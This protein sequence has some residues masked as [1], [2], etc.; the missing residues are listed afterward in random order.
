[1]VTELNVT[2][3]SSSNSLPSIDKI[4]SNNDENF[5]TGNKVVFRKREK[6]ENDHGNIYMVI[7][8]CKVESKKKDMDLK[9]GSTIKVV[10]TEKRD[11]GLIEAEVN[12]KSVLIPEAYLVEAV[13]EKNIIPHDELEYNELTSRIGSGAYG[14]VYKAKYKNEFVAFKTSINKMS[15]PN[16]MPKELEEELSI[17]S[18]LKNRN[19][20]KLIGECRTMKHMGLVIEYCAGGTLSDLI[21]K[22]KINDELCYILYLKQISDGMSYLHNDSKCKDLLIGNE[23]YNVIHRDLKPQNILIKEA[24]CEHDGPS[25]FDGDIVKCKKC[26]NTYFGNVTLK[27]ADFGLSKLRSQL[28][29]NQEKHFSIQGTLPYTA[30]EVIRGICLRQ[31]D[32]YSFS[33]I[34]WE[35]VHKK[36]PGTGWNKDNIFYEIG[37]NE[38]HLEFE[39]DCR[40]LYKEIFYLCNDKDDPMHRPSFQ[41]ISESLIKYQDIVIKERKE[42]LKIPD[43]KEVNEST[44]QLNC[45]LEKLRQ[46]VKEEK[47]DLE[48][49]IKELRPSIERL[50]NTKPELRK[51]SDITKDMIGLP[52]D[53]RLNCSWNSSNTMSRLISRNDFIERKK[54]HIPTTKNLKPNRPSLDNNN[55]SFNNDSNNDSSVTLINDNIADLQRK[56]AIRNVKISPANSIKDIYNNGC[57]K[58]ETY[59]YDT[60]CIE[61][62]KYEFIET[63]NQDIIIGSST[64]T[65][66]SSFEQSIS[67]D[68]DDID[69]LTV[70]ND[71]IVNKRSL[72]E[73]STSRNSNNNNG[74]INMPK[75]HKPHILNKVK[76]LIKPHK[77]YKNKESSKFYDS[78]TL[79]INDDG[80]ELKI[81]LDD[82]GIIKPN[83][84][85]KRSNT[86]MSIGSSYIQVHGKDH[87]R[88]ASSSSTVSGNNIYVNEPSESGVWEYDANKYLDKNDV[89][90]YTY[91]QINPIYYQRQKIKKESDKNKDGKITY[92][93]FRNHDYVSAETTPTIENKKNDN[94]KKDLEKGYILANQG[95]KSL[96]ENNS[97]KININSMENVENV[98]SI[99]KKFNGESQKPFIPTS[100]KIHHHHTHKSHSP[101]PIG[102][103][104]EPIPTRT[105]SLDHLTVLAADI[106]PPQVP[107]HRVNTLTFE[108]K[109]KKDNIEN[110][111]IYS[112]HNNTCKKETFIGDE[113][114]NEINFKVP[115]IPNK[116]P[117]RS[118][119]VKN[120]N[121]FTH[122]TD[123]ENYGYNLIKKNDIF[124]DE[125]K[126]IIGK[127]AFSFVYKA[128]YKN[129]IVAF[130]TMVSEKY[131]NTK[132]TSILEHEVNILKSVNHKNIIKL[133][134][135]SSDIK[136]MGILLEYCQGGTLGDLIHKW[137]IKDLLICLKYLQQICNGMSY[138]HNDLNENRNRYIH[139]DLKPQNILIKEKICDKRI[140]GFPMLY[141]TTCNECKDNC[142]F[143]SNLTLKIADFGL[144]R[145]NNESFNQIKGTIPYMAP[146]VH[147]NIC[148]TKSDVYSFSVLLWEMLNLESPIRGRSKENILEDQRLGKHILKMNSNTPPFL[149]KIF[150]TCHSYN[151]SER[152][153]FYDIEQ[154]IV[155]K[156]NK[157]TEKLEKNKINIYNE[158][159]KKQ[160]NTILKINDMIKKNRNERINEFN[161]LKDD[162]KKLRIKI[163]NNSFLSTILNHNLVK[164]KNNTLMSNS[165]HNENVF[166]KNYIEMIMKSKPIKINILSDWDVIGSSIEYNDMEINNE[167]ICS[168]Y[169]SRSSKKNIYKIKKYFINK[170]KFIK[171]INHNNYQFWTIFSKKKI[172][173]ISKK[174]KKDNQNNLYFNKFNRKS[175]TTYTFFQNEKYQYSRVKQHLYPSALNISDVIELLDKKH[176]VKETVNYNTNTTRN[177]VHNNF[178]EVLKKNSLLKRWKTSFKEKIFKNF[179]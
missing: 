30:P 50:M 172:D 85:N 16:K 112:I 133:I 84:Y 161:N 24:I 9:R 69:K 48:T 17:L 66:N 127:G 77:G 55:D 91:K 23:G 33:V 44:C 42:N 101:S 142:S 154:S 20:I 177:V 164:K 119:Q 2:C 13:R 64:S 153:S 49:V 63:V 89:E 29:D 130:K 8:E 150:E 104:I 128:Y 139:R 126:D 12:G 11:D 68:S 144:S 143:I 179:S 3:S 73:A 46:R 87:S 36:I 4:C 136:E 76:N 103:L 34:M 59:V 67:G 41:E 35:M 156:L 163:N 74:N 174:D 56:S 78:S 72:S 79:N 51:R 175:S 118:R 129:N 171:N 83:K 80:K 102:S 43:C 146:E 155:I 5:D 176:E 7:C 135:I 116:L 159:L 173:N 165:I 26:P 45:I 94:N 162:Y 123:N 62:I 152:P 108:S 53:V 158:I 1:M 71:F 58:G 88:N 98:S 166:E 61:F 113:S 132:I 137:K 19:I 131:C 6:N 52:E 14:T 21:H 22:R 99:I 38:F 10:K 140:S 96:V 110:N 149:V 121:I 170:Y 57:E 40:D 54:D 93:V 114:Y 117:V 60:D 122:T 124:F 107:S 100:L 31:S 92:N 109:N 27:I 167:S 81:S 65:I 25:I 169:G 47:R 82:N 141:K 178:S 134:G 90:S 157:L 120:M 32:V 115:Q 105:T 138:L 111:N 125:K 15:N 70:T 18:M 75:K 160:N 39:E 97:T 145:I 168:Y 37:K 86:T 147:Q 95:Y 106:E 28:K 148:N 151:Y